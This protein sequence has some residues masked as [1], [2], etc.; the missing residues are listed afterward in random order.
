MPVHRAV[1][2]KLPGQP[3]PLAACAQTEDDTIQPS[4]QIHAALPFG[5][6]RVMRVQEL[7]EDGP[8]VI[9]NFPDGRLLLLCDF[10]LSHSNRPF[11]E[12]YRHGNSLD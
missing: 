9:R 7:L 11:P 12:G 6:G 10:L 2:A 5:L 1:I 4:A 8:D 3:I